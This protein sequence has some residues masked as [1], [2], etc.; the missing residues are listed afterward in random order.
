MM[1][2][3]RQKKRQFVKEKIDKHNYIKT[4]RIDKYIRVHHKELEKISQA[5][6]EFDVYSYQK[7]VENM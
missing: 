1:S 7:I 3:I 5:L 6:E 2:Y 4:Q